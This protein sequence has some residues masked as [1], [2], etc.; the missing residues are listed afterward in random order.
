MRVSVIALCLA[1]CSPA[2]PPADG[3]PASSAETPAAEDIRGEWRLT[4]MNGRP[5]PTPDDT[6]AHHPITMT[7]GDFTMR[8]QSQCVAF[9]RRYEWKGDRL[10]VRAAN[11]GAMCAQGLSDW[12]REF[13]H[14]L[15]AITGAG[16]SGGALRLT[17]SGAA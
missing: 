9:W 15:S 4:A 3:R 7:V 8:A 6:D 12:E 1:A 17:G 14:T 5:A 2:A 16:R 13:S 10:I 11:P